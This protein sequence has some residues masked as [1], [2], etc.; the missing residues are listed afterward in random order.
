M[1]LS[2]R[3]NLDEYF[4]EDV[5]SVAYVTNSP[6]DLAKFVQESIDDKYRDNRVEKLEYYLGKKDENYIDSF[7]EDI[8]MGKYN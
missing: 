4:Y 7:V 3:Q 1:L 5:K 8:K 6:D 2:V